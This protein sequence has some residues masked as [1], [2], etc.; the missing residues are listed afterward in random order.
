MSVTLTLSPKELKLI[1]SAVA[2]VTPAGVN[3]DSALSRMSTILENEVAGS[4]SPYTGDEKFRNMR[5]FDAT[6]F[7]QI[8]EQCSGDKSQIGDY[9]VDGAQKWMD[10]K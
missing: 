9:V 5:M 3:P 10:S 4:E 8:I 1:A 6:I 2:Y 7:E